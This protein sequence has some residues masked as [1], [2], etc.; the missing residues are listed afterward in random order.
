MQK[1]FNSLDMIKSLCDEKKILFIIALYPDPS[2][3]MHKGRDLRRIYFDKML[4]YCEKRG[5]YC[6]DP[7]YEAGAVLKGI[8]EK[9][10]ETHEKE[11]NP[12]YYKIWGSDFFIHFDSHLSPKGHR[13][14]AEFLY[15]KIREKYSAIE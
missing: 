8:E 1:N 14:F 5:I 12:D 10:Y 6:I 7:F 15:G 4:D 13:W 9:Y 2:Y 11:D 3:Y